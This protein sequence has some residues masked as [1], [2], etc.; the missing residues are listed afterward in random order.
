MIEAGLAVMPMLFSRS[1]YHAGHTRRFEI[2]RASDAGWVVRSKV[3]TEVVTD[4]HYQDWHRVERARMTF[5][6]AIRSLENEG[7]TAAAGTIAPEA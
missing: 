2:A 1:L 3:D 6:T 4:A 7:W 5:E